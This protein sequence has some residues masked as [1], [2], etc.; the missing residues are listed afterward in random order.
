MNHK[1]LA[2]KTLSLG[3]LWL[4]P[5]TLLACVRPLIGQSEE[6]LPSEGSLLPLRRFGMTRRS[7]CFAFIP[8]LALLGVF[9]GLPWCASAQAQVNQPPVALAGP[10]Q[11]LGIPPLGLAAF[12]LDGSASFDPEVGSLT[13]QWRDHNGNVAGNSATLELLRAGGTYTFTLTVSDGLSSASDSVKVT[14]HL[15]SMAP[16][17]IPADDIGVSK[18]ESGGARGVDSPELAAFLVS[19]FGVDDLDRTLIQMTSQVAGA[20]V[21]DNTLFPIGLTVVTFRFRDSSGNVGAATANLRV[22]DLQSGDLFVGTN[23]ITNSF[24]QTVEPEGI[25]RVRSGA[26]EQWCVGAF[27][28]ADPLYFQTPQSVLMDSQG[29]VVFLAAFGVPGFAYAGAG[30]FRCESQGVTPELL[31]AF[32]FSQPISH[33]DATFPFPGD[34]FAAVNRLH[35]TRQRSVQIDDNA[36]NGLPRTVTEDAYVFLAGRWNLDTQTVDSLKTVRYRVASDVWEGGPEV[37]QQLGFRSGLSILPDVATNG[38]NTYS[39][40]AEEFGRF[41]EPLRVEITAQLGGVTAGAILRVGGGYL[42]VPNSRFPIVLVDDLNVPN[43][44]SGCP[45]PSPR[46][47]FP[48][49]TLMPIHGG[50]FARISFDLLAFDNQGKLVVQAGG[51]SLFLTDISKVFF[52]DND[53]PMPNEPH[54]T[55]PFAGCSVLMP[56]LEFKSM[57][58]PFFVSP[59]LLNSVNVMATDPQG[60]VGTQ[61]FNGNI[62]RIEEAPVLPVIATGLAQPLGI[63]AWPPSASSGSGAVVIIRIDSPVEVL[64]TDANGRRLGVDASGQP[65]NDFGSDGFDSGPGTHPRFYAVQN[66]AP[67]NFALQSVGTSAG[68]F[69]VHVY[70]A[71]LDKP[72]GEHILQSGT[73]SP[74]SV[75]KHDFTLDATGGLAFVNQAPVANAGG[76]QTVNADASGNATVT[77]DGSFSSDPDGDPLSFVWVGPF[78]IATGATPSVLLPAGVHVLTLKVDDGKGGTANDTV[79]VTV[80]AP[81]PSNQAPN[82]DAGLDQNVEATSPAGASVT[83]NGAGSS[84]PDGDTLTYGWTGSFGNASGATPTVSLPLGSHSITLEVSDGKGG[85]A[86]DAV[87]VTVQDTTAPTA[88]LAVVAGTLGGNGWYVGDVTVRTSGTDSASGIASCTADQFLTTDSVGAVFNG[89]CTDQAGNSADAQPLTV[90]RDATAPNT[91]GSASVSSIEATVALTASDAVSG[92]AETRY[93]VDGGAAQVYT[94]PFVLTGAGV[95][96]IEFFSTDVA[97]NV[98]TTKTLDVVITPSADACTSTNVLDNFNRGNGSLGSNWRG[99]TGT[100]FYR[101]AGN[102]VDVQ[103]GGPVYW[104]T[105]FGTSQA[106]FITLNTVD[107]KSPSQGVLAKLQSGSV[108]NAGA[109]AVVYDAVARAVRVSTLRLGALAWTHYG[110]TSVTVNNGDKLGACVKANG[111]VSVYQNDTLVKTAT[112]N[113]ADR[114]FFNSKG[115]KIGVWSV[116]APGAFFD[117]FGGGT[118]SP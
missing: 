102:R 1:I 98:E 105:T 48:V 29:R 42:Q 38:G 114:A 10:D 60:L 27:S 108:P 100:S 53:N 56:L 75:G 80:N 36:N 103:A 66:P 47:Q 104:N 85:S 64:L 34:M 26:I 55:N 68:P 83:L 20:D 16:L 90:K 94:G 117:D 35:L 89:A 78:G 7:R 51:P 39:V 97:G 13:H 46:P 106:A 31:G 79:I 61:F 32:P 11:E 6:P 44:D 95:Y 33:P 92:V 81:A 73:A 59:A 86:T 22:V 25:R 111:E 45:P 30:L 18:T 21:D 107:P 19:G 62:V 28:G 116:L 57:D 109:I 43:V 54:F 49:S 17:V 74:G 12:T 70:S 8:C 65:E 41:K 63:G 113:A 72:V 118:V 101:I 82:A 115:G 112:L 4:C 87:N 23:A 99:L 84:D 110:N 14:I 67:G 2:S 40:G 71:D 15:D 50:S 24:H 69:T 76:D 3:L 96:T 91:T 5:A 88:S 9:L 37:V 77:L 58:I 52:D 93:S